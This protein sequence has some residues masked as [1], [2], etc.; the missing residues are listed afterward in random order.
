M[1]TLLCV[2]CLALAYGFAR[3]LFGHFRYV[4]MGLATLVGLCYFFTLENLKNPTLIILLMIALSIRA[5][6]VL[7]HITREKL[8]ER[9][10][11]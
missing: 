7:K 8:A 5:L 1:I 11:L 3:N 6:V 10:G 4:F 2:I 9:E